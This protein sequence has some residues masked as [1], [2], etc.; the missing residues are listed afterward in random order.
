MMEQLRK[1]LDAALERLPHKNYTPEQKQ[2]MIKKA[3]LLGGVL[4]VL[5]L[6]LLTLVL[7][8]V[9]RVEVAQ[10]D[11]HYTD[12]EIA[13]ALQSRAVNPV[14]A[15]ALGR[16]EKQ[17]LDKLLYLESAEVRYAFPGTLR[18]SVTEQ[19]P[20]FYFPYETE[21]SGKP[22]AGWMLVGENLRIVDAGQD[23]TRYA[24][25]G[26]VRLSLPEPELSK[27]QPG[28]SSS[29]RFTDPE[30]KESTK[31]EADFAYITEF[32]GYLAQ[33][34]YA[35]SLTAVALEN[36][37]DVR[38]TVK[39]TWQIRFGRVKNATEFAQKM[40]LAQQ[41][42]AEMPTDEGQKYI[43][44]VGATVPYVRPADQIDL[45]EIWK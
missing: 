24:E 9:L 40:A 38:V 26:Y 16:G 42:L 44:D 43:V 20:L 8:P 36:K 34:D 6:L 11:S 7:F 2:A 21:L 39:G 4:A 45:D 12:E 18:V 10:N 13:D 27:T 32:L 19:D 22:H 5:A 15:M 14:L 35:D 37:F 25:L 1:W 41:M 29:L 31:T 33:S 17:L 30:D 28:R 23:S 3:T